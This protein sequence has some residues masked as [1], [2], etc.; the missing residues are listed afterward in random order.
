[1]FIYLSSSFVG[2]QPHC[3]AHD[4]LYA[5]RQLTDI[6]QLYIETLSLFINICAPGWYCSV[7]FEHGETFGLLRK[8]NSLLGEVFSTWSVKEAKSSS[9]FLYS[10]SESSCR[11]GTSWCFPS[12]RLSPE[13]YIVPAGQIQW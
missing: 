2:E 12:S 13:M 10:S 8:N 11:V 9:S 6:L 1:M 4:G 7:F 3:S 5:L